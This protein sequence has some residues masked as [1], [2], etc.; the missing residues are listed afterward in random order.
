MTKDNTKKEIRTAGN[1]IIK[2]MYTADPSARVWQTD[3]NRLYLYCSTDIAPPVGCDLMDQYHVFS[4]ENMVDWVDHGE[5]LRRDDLPEDVWGKHHDDAYFMWAPDAAYNQNHPAGK[6]PY[7]YYF[8]HSTGM[9]GAKG[10]S[11]ENW[12]CNWKLGVAHSNSPYQGFKDNEIVMMKDKNGVPLS[13]TGLLIDPCI[14]KEGETYYLATGGSQEFR[15]AKLNPDMVS[16]A[17]DFHVFTQEQLPHYHEGPWLFSRTNEAGI[18]YYYLMYPGAVGGVGDDMLYAMSKEGPYGP[19]EY[20]G[21]ILDPVGTGDTSHGSI[22]EFKG[23]WFLFYHN[24]DLSGGNST[25]RSVCVDELF[26]NQDGTIQ[27][28]QQT[29]SSVQPI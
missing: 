28:V 22:V 9:S 4:T 2:S 8:P 13:G 23:R 19:W 7:F 6:G 29:K 18:K 14:F 15:I 3:T 10:S 25:L 5:I 26:F 16:L 27:K 12:N 17:E 24:A 21:S 11:D 20:Q 1:P